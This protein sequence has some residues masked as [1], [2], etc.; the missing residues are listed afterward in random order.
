MKV[1]CLTMFSPYYQ[2]LADISVPNFKTYCDKHGYEFYQ[3]L[4]GDGDAWFKKNAAF[5]ECFKGNSDIIFYKDIDSLIT[6]L[7]VPIENFID[8]EHDFFITK[9]IEGINGGS[10]I[11]KNTKWSKSF[12][13]FVLSQKENYNNE[14]EVYAAFENDERFV[15]KIKILPQNTI[16]SYDYSQYETIGRRTHENGQWEVGDFVLHLPA[17]IIEKRLPIMKNIKIIE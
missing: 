15:D 5:D 1:I 8:D 6:N 16:N 4:V 10:L 2:P 7:T 11:M 17:L 14:Q 3:L 12:N 9:D 13:D